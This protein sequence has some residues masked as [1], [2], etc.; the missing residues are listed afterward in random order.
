MKIENP[1]P[2][3]ARTRLLGVVLCGGRSSR[4]GRDKTNLPHPFGGTFLEHAV[5]RI[6][7]VCDSASLST[8]PGQS[9][10][11][12]K[13][14]PRICDPIAHQGPMVGIAACLTYA[15]QHHFQ[16][17]LFTPVDMPDLT[18]EELVSL[19]DHWKGR[20]SRMVCAC[21]ADTGELQ[22]LVAVYP[23]DLAEPLGIAST[24]TD[25]SLVNWLKKNKTE[26]FPLAPS[27]HKNVNTPDD[28]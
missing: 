17:A 23:T 1:D 26:R 6:L 22:P 25:R 19:R 28:L 7:E 11:G 8:A 4:M 13:S 27:A 24:T 21:D 9:I 12:L 18:R 3:K 15:K 16:G 20:P 10:E 5:D 14:L 2:M